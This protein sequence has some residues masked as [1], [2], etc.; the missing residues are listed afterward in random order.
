V[1]LA[2]PDAHEV[3]LALFL[4]AVADKVEFNANKKSPSKG[5][6]AGAGANYL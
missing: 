3:F 4:Q 1:D 5:S 2:D 6:A